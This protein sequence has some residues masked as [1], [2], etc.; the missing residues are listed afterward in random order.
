MDVMPQAN[1][2]ASS[3]ARLAR[4]KA[5]EGKVTL[6]MR[7]TRARIRS[8]ERKI[9]QALVPLLRRGELGVDLPQLREALTRIER[10]EAD[11][12]RSEQGRRSAR[13]EGT[14]GGPAD[15]WSQ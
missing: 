12:E 3:L 13:S 1:K 15:E 14:A 7:R 4:E 9:G 10:L 2:T 5:K 6:D 8:E 11:L